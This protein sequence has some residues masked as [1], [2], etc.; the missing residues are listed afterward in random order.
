MLKLRQMVSAVLAGAVAIGVA[1]AP[2]AADPQQGLV[3]ELACDDGNAYTVIARAT[4][5]WNAQLVTDSTSVFHLTWY[6]IAFEVTAPD[7][8]VTVF[9]PFTVEK[10]GS[11]RAHKD[12]LTCAFTFD[13]EFDDGSTSHASGTAMGW[14]TPSGG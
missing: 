8:T 7:G 11:D 5:D 9:G 4:Q 12:L 2:A 3:V 13:L 6:E 14:P 10:G 1:A